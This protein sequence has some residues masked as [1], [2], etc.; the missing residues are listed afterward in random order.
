MVPE[1]FGRYNFDY[2]RVSLDECFADLRQLEFCRRKR[3]DTICLELSGCP[4]AQRCDLNHIFDNDPNL[5]WPHWNYGRRIP[6]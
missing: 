5:R 2:A 1:C 4:Q 3:L 6:I